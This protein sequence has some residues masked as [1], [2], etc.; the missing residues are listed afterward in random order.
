MALTQTSLS[1]TNTTAT[2]SAG[3][4]TAGADLTISSNSNIVVGMV[5]YV[6][7]GSGVLPA[8]TTVTKV[9]SATSIQLSSGT[10]T[11]FA[12]DT[13]TFFTRVLV[14]PTVDG[15]WLAANITV[16]N[17][18]ASQISVLL[19]DSTVAPNSYGFQ[20]IGVAAGLQKQS[21]TLGITSND[22]VYAT[23]ALGTSV[24]I[25]VLTQR[26]TFTPQSYTG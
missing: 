19:G 9:T 1:L 3:A 18:S 21:I 2:V 16:Q 24:P 22:A 23:C 15:K 8:G 5:V 25:S 4:Y 6:S 7:T 14:S 11:N 13:L 26:N 20:L 12:A 10:T 17:Q